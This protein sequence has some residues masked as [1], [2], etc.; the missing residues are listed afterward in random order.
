VQVSFA[1]TTDY[2]TL[3]NWKV[4][5]AGLTSAGI[6]KVNKLVLL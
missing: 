1:A 2:D 6:T 3:T 4:F 5:Q